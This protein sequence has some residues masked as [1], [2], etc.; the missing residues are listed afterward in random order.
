M[1][2]CP[3]YVQLWYYKAFMVPCLQTLLYNDIL[4]EFKDTFHDKIASKLRR[5]QQDSTFFQYSSIY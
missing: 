2:L 3:F 5:S 1:V 4:K